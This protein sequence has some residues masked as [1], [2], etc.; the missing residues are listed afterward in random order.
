LN[1]SDLHNVHKHYT[2]AIL[3]CAVKAVMPAME[4]VG[5]YATGAAPTHTHLA[6]HNQ[7][8]MQSLRHA[9]RQCVGALAYSFAR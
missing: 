9:G 2:D 3:V 6:I 7:V 5:W 8:M 4:L 1:I